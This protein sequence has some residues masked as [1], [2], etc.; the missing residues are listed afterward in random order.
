VLVEHLLLLFGSVSIR[1]GLK[2]QLINELGFVD[3]ADYEVS[4]IAPSGKIIT[5]RLLE[6]ANVSRR[7][8]HSVSITSVRFISRL[9]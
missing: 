1:A 7:I 8:V 9:S 5:S 2:L 4:F 6:Y 3:R